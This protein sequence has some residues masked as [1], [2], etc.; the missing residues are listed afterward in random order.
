MAFGLLYAPQVRFFSHRH[1]TVNTIWSLKAI[2]HHV[3]GDD[4]IIEDALFSKRFAA[5]NP[6]LYIDLCPKEVVVR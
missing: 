2:D 4:E 3:I 5:M 1:H 6:R